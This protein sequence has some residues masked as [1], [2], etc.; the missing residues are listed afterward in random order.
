MIKR[1]V[2]ERREKKYLAEDLKN[3]KDNLVTIKKFIKSDDDKTLQKITNILIHHHYFFYYLV[4]H[5]MEKAQEAY[6]KK[7]QKNEFRVM[8][9]YINHFTDRNEG[10]VIR[11]NGFH[12]NQALIKPNGCDI[13]QDIYR[14][15][16]EF[17]KVYQPAVDE[18][19]LIPSHIRLIY[20][21]YGDKVFNNNRIS[22]FASH[23][24]KSGYPCLNWCFLNLN[25]LERVFIYAT[26]KSIR[27]ELE[28]YG[29]LKEIGKF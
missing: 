12:V 26:Y 11:D 3:I 22:Q 20:N 27:N 10:I 19:Y 13:E 6:R 8:L 15:Y 16:E 4:L 9:D 28:N 17:N 21:T 29:K 7:E 24:V 25:D 23:N 18:N 2:Q 1:I 14:D 5:G